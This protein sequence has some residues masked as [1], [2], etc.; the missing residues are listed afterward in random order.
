M[1]AS[2]PLDFFAEKAAPPSTPADDASEAS[3]D[4]DWEPGSS[5]HD[6]DS[7]EDSEESD[8]TDGDEEDGEESWRRVQEDGAL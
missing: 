4:G 6:D 2:L 3:V 1:L 8:S 5:D 7:E